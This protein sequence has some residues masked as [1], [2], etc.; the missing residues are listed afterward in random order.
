M[1]RARAWRL[2][3]GDTE[4]V[5]GSALPVLV[6]LEDCV[7]WSG[8]SI[9]PGGFIASLDIRSAAGREPDSASVWISSEH[10]LVVDEPSGPL[11]S[12]LRLVDTANGIA[13]RELPTVWMYPNVDLTVHL[14]RQP[15]DGWVGFD[16]TVSW[17]PTGLGVTSTVLHDRAGPVGHVHQ[18]QTVRPWARAGEPR[19]SH[20]LTSAF[21]GCSTHECRGS[22]RARTRPI[23]LHLGACVARVEPVPLRSRGC[24]GEGAPA[25][26][27]A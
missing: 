21:E 6:A 1:V 12:F 13:V 3:V 15:L 7:P 26:R 18:A 17:G 10:E 11:A 5:A 25:K 20:R 4:S 16:T 23:A 19:R 9:W 2:E 24:H 14:F 22:R 8:S 27:T